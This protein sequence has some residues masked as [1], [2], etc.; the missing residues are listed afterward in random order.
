MR[1]NRYRYY[2]PVLGRFVSRDPIGLAGGLN[3]YQYAPNPIEWIDPLGLSR[4]LKFGT[5]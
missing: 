2:D 5:V 1:Y 3:A 4:L